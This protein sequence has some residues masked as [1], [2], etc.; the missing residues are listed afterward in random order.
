MK[1]IRSMQVLQSILWM[2]SMIKNMIIID[3]SYITNMYD[4]F[5]FFRDYHFVAINIYTYKWFVW[6]FY[7]IE[8]FVFFWYWKNVSFF[9]IHSFIITSKNR[10]SHW[11]FDDRMMMIIIEM[12]DSNSQ[13]RMNK[14]CEC[15]IVNVKWKFHSTYFFSFFII[16]VSF[17]NIIWTKIEIE[18]GKYK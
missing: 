11:L 8:C 3:S 12:T 18:N 15:V 5:S 10:E 6:Y 1:E 16:F 9:T 4:N 13:C 14:V 17:Q 2:V 7:R